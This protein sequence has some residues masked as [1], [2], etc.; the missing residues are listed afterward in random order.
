MPLAF[1]LLA[2]VC[3]EKMTTQD[4]ESSNMHYMTNRY[5]RNQACLAPGKCLN[6]Y[7]SL[8]DCYERNDKPLCA[9]ESK[10]VSNTPKEAKVG[11][12][13]NIK[14]TVITRSGGWSQR[15]REVYSTQHGRDMRNIISNWNTHN[16]WMFIA[17]QHTRDF[18][19]DYY[20]G[21]FAPTRRV[22][23]RC[24]NSRHCGYRTLPAADCIHGSY[25]YCVTNWS[26]GF[27]AH[28]QVRLCSADTFGVWGG[29]G[30]GGNHK[31][32]WH[33][34][35]WYTGGWRAGWVHNMNSE[36]SVYKLVYT[37]I[38]NGCGQATKKPTAYPTAFPTAYPTA[39]PTPAVC[40]QTFCTVSRGVTNVYTSKAVHGKT[41]KWDCQKSGSGCVCLCDVAHSQKCTLTHTSAK[42]GRVATNHC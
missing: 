15:L 31:L 3:A 33:M 37:K 7:C 17:A 8:Y 39:Y 32:S 26:F 21:A 23:N 25:W 22:F 12:H 19:N 6:P 35:Y 2:A 27:S 34:H 24:N 28:N 1:C 11:I 30:N 10:S 42:V 13:H 9:G 20:I 41:E 40:K 4:A 36:R 38:C 29:H 5:A 18:G 14:E 16:M